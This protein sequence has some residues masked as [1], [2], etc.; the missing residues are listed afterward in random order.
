MLA[1]RFLW[2]IVA[3]VMLVL[4]GAI[5][6]R[7]FNEQIMRVAF[8]PSKSFEASARPGAPDYARIENWIARPD[9]KDDPARWTPAR[10]DSA[11]LAGI[12]AFYIAPTS[13]LGRD[14]W[15]A[16]LDDEDANARLEL[17]TRSQASVMNGVAAIWA[18]RYRQATFGAFLTD[19]ADA[20]KALDLAYEDVAAAF[21]AFVASIPPEQPILLAGHSQG[22]LHLLRLL[23]QKVAGTPLAKR[24][25]AVY[26]GGWPVSV[27]ADIPALGLPGCS[28]AAEPGCIVA[29]Q[30]FAEPAEPKMVT[31]TF[32]R[33]TGLTGKSRAGT[34]ML[35]VNPLTGN[36]GDGAP[37][38]ANRGALVPSADFT[39]GNL[40]RGSVPARCENGLLLIGAP[41]EG[42]DKFVL[43]GNNFHVYDYA[44]FWANLRADVE[45]RAAAYRKRR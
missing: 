14:R 10:H 22:S 37:A 21:D 35:C 13:Y 34:H 26:A 6:Y 15:N 1:R 23:K 11:P 36:A 40:V 28:R 29:W 3:L 5:A 43:P 4:A 9:F 7:L 31:E 41:P 39:S 2:V 27:E 25:V 16:P 8:V 38:S 19:K 30:S 17:F 33:S 12:A 45:A 44:L 32:A 18:P 42:F 24:I 20:Q